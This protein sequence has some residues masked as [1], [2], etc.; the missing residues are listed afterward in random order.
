[1]RRET[2]GDGSLDSDDVLMAEKYE[3]EH[4]LRKV[5]LKMALLQFL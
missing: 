5:G 3:F 2:P 1:M 4:D